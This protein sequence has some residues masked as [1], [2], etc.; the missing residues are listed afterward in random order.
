LSRCD[1]FGNP[2]S[3]DDQTA[4]GAI[5]KDCKRVPNPQS[6]HDDYFNDLRQNKKPAPV[7]AGF[8]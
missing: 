6:R 7:G 4:L 5:G 2:V 1:T 8:R 3:F